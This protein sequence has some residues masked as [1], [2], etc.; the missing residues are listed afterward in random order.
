MLVDNIEKIINQEL[1]PQLTADQWLKND[2]VA[3]LEALAAVLRNTLRTQI[4]AGASNP[5]TVSG[6]DRLHTIQPMLAP[7]QLFAQ[8]DQVES[9]LASRGS[10]SNEDLALRVI[11]LGFQTSV[12][13]PRSM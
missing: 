13:Q 9:W 1:D 6:A 8:L 2:P 7:R 10:G 12:P 5:I 11:L 3:W 4:A